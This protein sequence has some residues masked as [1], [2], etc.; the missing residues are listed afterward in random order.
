[1]QCGSQ[2]LL[3]AAGFALHGQ[4]A[5]PT[6]PRNH[7]PLP[8]LVRRALDFVPRIDPAQVVVLHSASGLTKYLLVWGYSPRISE[9]TVNGVRRLAEFVIDNHYPIFVNAD[10]YQYRRILTSWQHGKEPDQAARVLASDLYHEY[11]HTLGEEEIE[12]LEAQVALLAKWRAERLLTIAD[13]YIQ[14]KQVELK[15]LRKRAQ[16]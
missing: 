10:T 9:E 13:P 1:V 6:A 7:Q 2:L 5:A 3:L 11:R 15:T 12:A 14:A 16:R 8:A 4:T